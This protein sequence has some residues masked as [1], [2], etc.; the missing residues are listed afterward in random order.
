M[1]ANIPTTDKPRIVIVGGGFAGLKLARE[2]AKSPVQIVLIDKNNFHQFQ[3][4]FYQ[5]A[6]A[7]LEPS[8]ILFPLRKVFQSH[9]NIHIRVTELLEIEPDKNRIQTDLGPISYDE[10][11]IAVGASTNFFGMKNVQKYSR[12]MKSV[13]E[14]L[15]LRNTILE[16]YEKALT[17]KTETEQVALMNIAVVGGGP[18]GVEVSGTLAEMRDRI[19][20]KDY[21]EL[22][23]QK[24]NIY[25]IEA[26]SQLLNGMSE[27]SSRKSQAYLRK[28]GVNVLLGTLVTDYDGN[29]ITTKDGTKIPSK[30][31]VWAAGIMGNPVNGLPQEAFF[32]GGRLRT[33]GFHK[34]EG[35]EN[36][37]AVGDISYMEADKNYPNGHP[38]VA[39]VAIQQAENLGKNLKNKLKH[40]VPRSFMYKDLGSMATVGKNLAVV[41]LPF[42]KFQG[43]MAWLVW[44]FVHL[45]SIVGVKNRLLIFVNWAWNYVTYDQSLRLIIRSNTKEEPKKSN[46]TAPKPTP[47]IDEDIEEDIEPH[48]EIVEDMEE[49]SLTGI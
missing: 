32:R 37:Y 30:T 11:V 35:T 44:M 19:L 13:N 36:I 38:Q 41:D 9:K 15:S 20:P 25:L 4:L 29:T 48:Y 14:A 24:M 28:L 40:R 34:V 5:V 16:N 27:E 39:Q 10:L 17:A 45:M 3:P 49:E 7:G 1:Q 42:V 21:P 22:N 33:D 43:F 6:T 18:T 8:S 47:I 2:L 12:P 46:L 26:S 31:L 23:F